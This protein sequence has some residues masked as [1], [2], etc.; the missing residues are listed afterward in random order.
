MSL[1]I[2]GL[3]ENA[4]DQF[5]TLFLVNTHDPDTADYSLGQTILYNVGTWFFILHEEYGQEHKVYWDVHS[6]DIQR[7]YNIS[8]YAYGHDPDYNQDLIDEGW[9]PVE[10]A[11]SCEY[12]YM[13]LEK[14]W[15]ILLSEYYKN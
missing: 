12:E 14:N 5:A 11:Q 3:E 4:V 15:N 10:R 2:T 6:L 1:P 7:F 13:Q 8:C 9:L